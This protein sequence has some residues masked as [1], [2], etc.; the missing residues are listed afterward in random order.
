MDWSNLIKVIKIPLKVLIPG[1]WL[2]SGFFL[3]CCEEILSKL[4]L[5]EC[6]L[7]MDLYLDYYLLYH[8]V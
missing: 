7:K 2:F 4:N 3:F 5:L 8:H 6:L 1:T